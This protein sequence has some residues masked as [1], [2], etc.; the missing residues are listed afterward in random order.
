M[1]FTDIFPRGVKV[2]LGELT[3]TPAEITRFA[4]AFDPQVF[5]L[6][7]EKAQ[8]SLFG[9]LCASGW[10]TTAGWM[11]CFVHFCQDETRR[12]AAEGRAVPRLGPSPGFRELKWLKPV[13]AGDTITFYLTALD[14]EPQTRPDRRIACGIG[15]GEN[16]NG[17]EVMRFENR[18]I[19]FV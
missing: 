8:A 17:E 6:D 19:E 5:H 1:S 4:S 2:T 9:G 18:V 13:Y 11:K 16:Q 7:A 10:H 12:L 14:P 3:Y 15:S